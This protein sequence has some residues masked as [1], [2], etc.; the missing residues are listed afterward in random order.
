LNIDQ[1]EEVTEVTSD[2]EGSHGGNYEEDKPLAHTT[3]EN[4][5]LN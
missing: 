1:I 4:T 5:A 3:K 2:I